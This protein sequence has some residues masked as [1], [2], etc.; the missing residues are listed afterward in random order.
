MDVIKYDSALNKSEYIYIGSSKLGSK[1]YVPHLKSLKDYR[2]YVEANNN[3][4]ELEGKTL[5][6]NCDFWKKCHGHILVYLLMQRNNFQMRIIEF[7]EDSSPLSNSYPFPFQYEGELFGSLAHAYYWEKSNRN[8][9]LLDQNSLKSVVEL[10]SKIPLTQR[11]KITT[12]KTI[13]LFYLLLCK[14]YELCVEFQRLVD[15][16]QDNFILQ[17]TPNNFWGKG[18]GLSIKKQTGQNITGWLIMHLKR[19]NLNLYRKKIIF[20]CEGEANLNLMRGLKLVNALV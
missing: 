16:H 20:V 19:R 15:K 17:A 1:W 10:F 5:T 18:N 9:S 2:N 8:P 6:C 12:Q 11:C 7:S 4:E 3:I 13:Q 14:K